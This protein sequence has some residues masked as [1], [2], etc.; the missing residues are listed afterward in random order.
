MVAPFPVTAQRMGG[1]GIETSLSPFAMTLK[2]TASPVRALTVFGSTTR[3]RTGSRMIVRLIVAFTFSADAWI[4]AVPG[5]T[6]VTT[7]DS[8]TAAIAGFDED[9]ITR[10]SVRGSP[11]G[12]RV[13]AFSAMLEPAGIGVDGP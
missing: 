8:S 11:F 12:M 2:C 9:Q 4:V 6:P 13:I 1:V 5:A 10:T 7:P 3:L